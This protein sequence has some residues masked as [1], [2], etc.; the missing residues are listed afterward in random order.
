MKSLKRGGREIQKE[1]ARGSKRNTERGR[2]RKEERD[3]KGGR[4]SKRLKSCVESRSEEKK[5]M[6]KIRSMVMRKK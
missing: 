2:K 5:R 1:E 4:K 6:Q 3:S